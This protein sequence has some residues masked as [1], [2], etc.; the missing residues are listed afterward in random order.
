MVFLRWF[1]ALTIAAL[2]P[3]SPAAIAQTLGAAE[4]FA[5]LG[6]N[7]VTGNGGLIDGDVGVSPGTSVTGFP[8][9][10]IGPG[11]GLHINDTAAQAARTA[12]ASLYG[13]LSAQGPSTL[14]MPQLAGTTVTPGVYRFTSS[15]DISSGGELT[16]NGAGIY[17]FQVGSALT[18][19]V[20]SFVTLIG[21]ATPCNVYFQVTTAATLNGVNFPGTI[22][23]QAGVTLGVGASLTGRALATAG[24]VTL[25]GANQLGGCSAPPPCPPITL[26]PTLLP[27]GTVGAMY[28]QQVTASGGTAPYVFAISSGALP[29]GLTLS[30]SGLISG[31]PTTTGVFPFTVEATDDNGCLGARD[32]TITIVPAGC[33]SISIAPATLP[34]GTLTV[35]YS[36]QLTASGGTGPYTFTL[37]SGTL[38]TGLMLS[39]AGLISGTPTAAGLFTFEVQATDANMCFGVRGYTLTVLP[40]GCPVITLSP[41][42]LPNGT[43]G[44]AYS[45]Q[46]DASGGA[47]PYTFSLAS[48]ALPPGLALSAAGLISGTPTDT[49]VF[50]FVAQATDTNGCL[51]TR[52]YSITVLCP[53]IAIAPATL[54]SADVGV[55][56]NQQL[57]ASG[58]NGPYAFA[59][60][61]GA[62]PPGLTLSGAGLVAGTPTTTGVFA[63]MVRATDADGCFANRAYAITVMLVGCPVITVAP[64]TLPNGTVGIPYSQNITASGGTGPYTFSVSFGALP[65]GLSLSSGG[66]LSGTPL[67][68]GAFGFAITATDALGCFGALAYTV[69]AASPVPTLP[70]WALLLLAGTLAVASVTRLR[71]GFAKP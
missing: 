34:D 42:T 38:P 16:L 1:A 69:V 66:V 60:T 44:A 25:A 65:T 30:A 26:A 24:P 53:V 54:P 33:P 32:Y 20:G 18:A 67:T 3:S 70:E 12:T 46:V 19:N 35:A 58:G 27:D 8:P 63:F 11:F 45:E 31:T 28:S 4:S 41:S 52:A 37:S 49:G 68:A 5:I 57:T 7:A 64:L 9:T 15:A 6:Q 36:Q 17:I 21:G 51:G 43:L 71:S 39:A 61:S 2:G 50:S 40:P 55:V 62:L 10:L 59:L 56:Y 47:A 48:G 22:V 13:F 29:T 14:L 23:A